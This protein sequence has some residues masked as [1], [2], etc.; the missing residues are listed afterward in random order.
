MKRL[1]CLCKLRSNKQYIHIFHYLSVLVDYH[2]HI[3]LSYLYVLNQH[4]TPLRDHLCCNY[5]WQTTVYLFR[6]NQQCFQLQHAL[7]DRSANKG[8]DANDGTKPDNL[9][10]FVHCCNWTGL[11]NR[12]YPITTTVLLLY[13]TNSSNSSVKLCSRRSHA[14]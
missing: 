14:K 4:A 9:T 10:V 8:I 3:W 12:T 11:G 6:N 5:F 7:P 13:E 2:L 1:E